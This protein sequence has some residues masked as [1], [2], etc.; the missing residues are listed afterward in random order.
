M[1]SLPRCREGF[2]LRIYRTAEGHLAPF[3]APTVKGVS[4]C[5]PSYSPG[6]SAGFHTGHRGRRPDR[7]DQTRPG[8]RSRR[9]GRFAPL[10]MV[11]RGGG[12]LLG[13]SSSCPGVGVASIALQLGTSWQDEKRAA[14]LEGTLTPF[15]VEVAQWF[16]AS[17]TRNNRQ[18]RRDVPTGAARPGSY[19]AVFSGCLVVVICSA[20]DFGTMA[21]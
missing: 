3:A 9:R 7:H 15:S 6:D 20:V 2:S 19:I 4:F 10:A 12:A 5:S 16:P 1:V 8:C 21:K 11:R 13:S 14:H 17:F 18:G